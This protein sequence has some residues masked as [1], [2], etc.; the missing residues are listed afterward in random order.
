MR[1][2]SMGV[3]TVALVAGMMVQSAE[4]ASKKPADIQEGH[5]LFQQACS[6]CHSPTAHEQ[7]PALAEAPALTKEAVAGRD[8]D[9]LDVIK[10]G[11]DKKMPGFKYAL[12]DQ[13]ID[14]I[15]AYLNTVSAITGPAVPKPLPAKPI[16]HEGKLLLTGT[17]KSARGEP[18]EG[19]SVAA[20]IDG[21][22]ITVAVLTDKDGTYYFPPMAGATYRLS[23]QAIGF[24]A[25]RE[26]QH[27]NPT[28]PLGP[29]I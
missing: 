27:K 29:L 28:T 15:V 13:E 6:V 26:F 22:A 2:F 4:A 14:Q 5:R 23:A 17:V 12:K 20:R 7:T 10:N 1:H 24:E 25:G 3:A 19:V 21:Q 18:M 9:I 8:R 16:L 11:R